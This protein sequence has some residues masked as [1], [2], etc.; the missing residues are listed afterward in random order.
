M[1]PAISVHHV[2][3]ANEVI[4]EKMND[5]SETQEAK[6]ES[7]ELIQKGFKDDWVGWIM[8]SYMSALSVF[9]IIVL[10]VLSLDY[11]GYVSQRVLLTVSS[12]DRFHHR[13]PAHLLGYF[14][15]PMI[16]QA[17]HSV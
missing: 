15:I 9:W 17:R 16:C 13:S 14:M 2:T 3:V 1:D 7:E 8:M 11:Y 5:P 4:R 6:D 10:L 12:T